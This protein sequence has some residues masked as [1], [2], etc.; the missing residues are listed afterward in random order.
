MK[1]GLRLWFGSWQGLG[2]DL[3]CVCCGWDDYH[4]ITSPQE[5]L[6]RAI[7]Q[8]GLFPDWFC[9][10]AFQTGYPIAFFPNLRDEKKEIEDHGESELN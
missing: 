3:D 7:E 5:Q 6:C 8:D 9:S 2:L 10:R 4:F 1:E